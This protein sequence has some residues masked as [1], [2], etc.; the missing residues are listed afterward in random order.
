ML[1]SFLL[2]GLAFLLGATLAAQ[3]VTPT[4]G[5]VTVNPNSSGNEVVF[6]VTTGGPP[7]FEWSVECTYG[8]R[9]ASCA[10]EPVNLNKGGSVPVTVTFSA[11]AVGLGNV[12]LDLYDGM[13]AVVSGNYSV[14]VGST[15]YGVA[16]TPDGTGI[17][18]TANTSGNTTTFTVQN[19]GNVTDTYAL[20]CT[21]TAPVTS[22]NG[23]TTPR[24]VVAGGSIV[25]T[26][27]Y[28]VGSPGTG[29][30]T[31]TA[32]GQGPSTAYDQ[33]SRPVSVQALPVYGVSVS[34]DGGTLEKYTEGDMDALVMVTNTGNTTVS[35]TIN[36]SG[37]G[38]VAPSCAGLQVPVA[39]G[40]PEQV[41][42]NFTTTSNAGG[43]LTV[44]ATS[45]NASDNGS[46]TLLPGYAPDP[47]VADPGIV[48]V[49]RYGAT[50]TVTFTVYNQTQTLTEQYDLS[51][52]KSGEIASCLVLDSPIIS[53]G[54][55]APVRLQVTRNLVGSGMVGLEASTSWCCTIRSDRDS[56]S[57]W[58][59]GDQQV[60]VVS[61][62]RYNPH[63][64]L[65]FGLC[66]TASGGPGVQLACGTLIAAHSMPVFRTLGRDRALALVYNGGTASPRPA[67]AIRV[68][69]LGTQEPPDSL[70][71]TIQART[72]AGGPWISKGTAGYV[73]WLHSAAGTRQIVVGWAEDGLATGIYPIRIVVQALYPAAS[74]A[75]TV[76]GELVVVNR[77]SSPFGS[78]WWVGGVEDLVLGADR[79]GKNRIV[80][81]GSDGSYAAY[82]S[83]S[84]GMWARPAGAFRDTL[85]R[86]GSEYRRRLLH[87]DSI[88]Y[89]SVGRHAWTKTRT[90]KLTS[91]YWTGATLTSIAVP[92]DY[93][94]YDFFYSSSL[95]DS[96][97]DPANRRLR[98]ARSG[99]V[100]TGFTDPDSAVTGYG[101]DGGRRVVS[102]TTPRGYTTAFTWEWGKQVNRVAQPLSVAPGDSAITTVTWTDARG[103]TLGNW[104][105][106][107]RQANPIA[108]AYT[109]I[110]GPRPGGSD[111]WRF[112][113][114]LWGAPIQAT[115]PLG[116]I[117]SVFRS[118]PARPALVTRA[119]GPDRSEMRA[120]YN[121]TGLP[122]SVR[123]QSLSD[124]NGDGIV[125]QGTP[126]DG[127]TFGT[128]R[129]V[130][131]PVWRQPTRVTGPDGSYTDFGYNSGNGRLEWVQDARGTDSRVTF[132][133]DPSCQLPSQAWEPG[134]AQPYRLYYDA[135]CNLRET[136]TP[137]GLVSTVSND[138]S[139]LPYT[140]SAPDGV[141]TAIWRDARNGRDTL[142][143]TSGDA[144]SVIVNGLP[145]YYIKRVWPGPTLYLSKSY[146]L[147]GNV[148]TVRRWGVPSQAGTIVTVSRYD[149]AGRKVVEIGADG[150]RDSTV[151]DEAGN[152]V[153][154]V[155]RRGH[156]I[157]MT[158]DPAGQMT[159]RILPTVTY[160]TEYYAN[161]TFPKIGSQ[162]VIGQD[163]QFFTY[164][165]GGRLLTANN[166]YARI[167]RTYGSGGLMLTERQ[168]VRD[169]SGPTFTN[170]SYTLAWT[171]DLAGRRR[172]MTLP[173][174]LNG[175]QQR[176]LTY[177]YD[178]FGP[179]KEIGLPG[180]AGPD[181]Y[182]WRFRYDLAGRIDSI[183]NPNNTGERWRYDADGRLQRRTIRSGAPVSGFPGNVIR[184][185][186]IVRNEAGRILEVNNAGRERYRFKYAGLGAVGF[187]A[188]AYWT[189][190]S[191]QATRY[192][193]LQPD[194]FGNP[195][196]AYSQTTNFDAPADTFDFSYYAWYTEPTGRL[197]R[198]A[199]LVDSAE[200]GVWRWGW[201]L[202]YD[203]SGNQHLADRYRN[204]TEC[205]S[206]DAVAC[207]EY[208]NF[209][210]Q[211]VLG[212]YYA[213][214]GKLMV[215]DL[216][217]AD[218][219]PSERT[220][221]GVEVMW[222]D[223]L[224]RR[225][226]RIYDSETIFGTSG[227]YVLSEGFRY[228]WDGPRT[229]YE[230]RPKLIGTGANPDNDLFAEPQYGRVLYVEGPGI[231][232]PLAAVRE[233]YASDPVFVHLDFRDQVS[234]GTLQSGIKEDQ[235]VNWANYHITTRGQR[236][237]RLNW[238]AGSQT[239][240]GSMLTWQFGGTGQVYLRNRYFDSGSGRFTQED[241]IGLAGGLNLYGFANGDP[242]NFS[243]PFGLCIWD[244]CIV[245]FVAA[246]TAAFAAIRATANLISGRPIGEHVLRDAQ[247]GF[248]AATITAPVG[249][250]AGRVAAAVEAGESAAATGTYGSV[251]VASKLEANAAARIW[252]GVGART[253]TQNRAGAAFG[254]VV[255]RISAD[256]TRVAR[257]AASK[258]NG[259][260]AANLE[261]LLTGSNMHVVVKP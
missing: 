184:D 125:D 221:G 183:Q 177:R 162:L 156:T 88:A 100:V 142:T 169:Y 113:E 176:Q 75:D 127:A 97:I 135:R 27:T 223:A 188:E 41:P 104:S 57:T 231:D 117:D 229:L 189:G 238:N 196:S 21:P 56:A 71:I 163:I 73:S 90:G 191:W 36:C 64:H 228:V 143:S 172:T 35:F 101:S 7:M 78:G 209:N 259:T 216:R 180:A 186:N 4:N 38:A 185:D 154:R 153:A 108:T 119:V 206:G 10:T 103:E 118:D 53:P 258:P 18:A 134:A 193:Y 152:P 61:L 49:R 235:Y 222:Y 150:V 69:M 85:V 239:W 255:G 5:S 55:A 138:A 123:N 198:Q 141:V 13:F 89:T 257:F 218:P 245:E 203:S 208:L 161:R 43:T 260:V 47:R 98:V 34:P 157:T 230:I 86:V 95:L 94:T 120:W 200:G 16:V 12:S 15:T 166:N 106:A 66:V 207:Y 28:A 23:F 244:G 133:Y 236:K 187:S 82:D 178:S 182:V 116:R 170:H 99:T 129:Y 253:I 250:A 30:L 130:Y 147:E 190:S 252:A 149:A 199:H 195:E 83:V 11:G 39:P 146:D 131:Q 261:D 29:G 79:G 109:E 243:D 81:L 248:T 171:Y 105:G 164:D 58:V 160:P 140:L 46:F 111:V 33:G 122:D 217:T 210:Y 17:S 241:P 42:I 65:D 3:S 110:N 151:Y 76:G 204:T 197:R 2:P 139:G 237:A 50:D 121:A 60:P 181:Q 179:L 240:Y 48:P 63:L 232:R 74:Y 68:Q 194:A 84:P 45:P 251:Q 213:A 219:Y 201:A 93:S 137:L 20:T 67:Q 115:D 6:T 214:D 72:T 32:D 212:S 159:R 220:V 24:T 247:I 114:D 19:T 107:L 37:T 192:E 254:Q 40:S 224:G 59:S 158:Y 226:T 126:G 167:T 128:T 25:V 246:T 22:C 26:V 225:V 242:V 136:R 124:N 175:G 215:S 233:G 234:W 211:E 91:F 14:Q 31:V 148:M 249:A 144:D 77:R 202:K 145:W 165:L 70:K 8:G 155:T 173:T 87:G 1:R 174:E 62:E 96:V 102:R 80:W 51:C 52:F 256:A 9:V 92:P 227:Q 168:Q 112:S 54:G 205:N 44:T 132:A